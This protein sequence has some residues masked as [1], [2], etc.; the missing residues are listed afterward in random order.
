MVTGVMPLP[1]TGEARAQ[2]IWFGGT[3]SDY[4]TAS[5]WSPAAVPNSTITELLFGPAALNT[6]ISTAAGSNAGA[7]V[8]EAG[9]P[10]FVFNMGPAATGFGLHG[11]GIVNNSGW[12]RPSTCISPA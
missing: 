11:T 4:H 6:T 8:F 1:F 12:F 2:A 9:A 10:S 7:L 5:N 3:D